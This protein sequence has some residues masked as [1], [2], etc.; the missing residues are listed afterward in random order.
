MLGNISLTTEPEALPLGLNFDSVPER[1]VVF[2]FD[3]ESGHSEERA[4]LRR[5]AVFFVS[6]GRQ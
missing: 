3:S 1:Q 6:V 4:S 5:V 2:S